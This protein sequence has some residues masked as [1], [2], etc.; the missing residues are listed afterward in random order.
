MSRYKVKDS[1][2]I[3]FRLDAALVKE[4]D[5]YSKQSLIPKTRIV[6]RALTEFFDKQKSSG[7]S[8]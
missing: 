3:S 1:N 2:P 4:L 8:L 7:E 5:E 6:E